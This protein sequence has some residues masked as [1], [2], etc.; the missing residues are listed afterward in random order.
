M[1][2]LMFWKNSD[3]IRWHLLQDGG[4]VLFPRVKRQKFSSKA[5][6]TEFPLFIPPRVL[7][8]FH[9]FLYSWCTHSFDF[10]SIGKKRCMF[11]EI[12]SCMACS[13][14]SQ[15]FLVIRGEREGE[16]D[17]ASSSV[18]HVASRIV[19][20]F[21][22]MLLWKQFQRSRGHPSFIRDR[23]FFETN[24]VY[25]KRV[26]ALHCIHDFETLNKNIIV[27]SESC[28]SF[29]MGRSISG[30]P[31]FSTFLRDF[32]FKSTVC[33]SSHRIS[34]LNVYSVSHELDKRWCRRQPERGNIT[35]T[36]KV[37]WK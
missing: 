16:R 1:K 27:V 21:L 4:H 20:V 30:K 29:S 35:Q 3:V 12:I 31:D 7:D 15:I 14:H 33:F 5:V 13:F 37:Q 36:K 8:N 23:L 32:L 10:C 11:V 6:R 18:F 26:C 22:L 9:P 19:H 2:T 25:L 34:T 17:F 24:I 28:L